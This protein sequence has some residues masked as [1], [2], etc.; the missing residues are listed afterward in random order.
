MKTR[1]NERGNYFGEHLRGESRVVFL[2][3]R[4]GWSRDHA[5][6]FVKKE[7]ARMVSSNMKRL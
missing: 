3:N 7:E 5:T 4:L 1:R 2:T 6:E